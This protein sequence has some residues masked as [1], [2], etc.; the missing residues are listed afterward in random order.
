MHTILESQ[1]GEPTSENKRHVGLHGKST[2]DLNTDPHIMSQILQEKEN[3]I[4]NLENEITDMRKEIEVQRDQLLQVDMNTLGDG[5]TK[6]ND[7]S[8]Y[9]SLNHTTTQNYYP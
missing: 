5:G 1:R 3:Y 6:V 8:G 2:S 9:M 4:A 7:Q